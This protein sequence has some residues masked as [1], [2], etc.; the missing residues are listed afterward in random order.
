MKTIRTTLFSALLTTSLLSAEPL[1]TQEG[2]DPSFAEVLK[3][4]GVKPGERFSQGPVLGSR[5]H[6]N[7]ELLEKQVGKAGPIPKDIGLHTEGS[8]GIN[9]KDFGKWTRWYQEDGNTQVFRLFKG[10]Q[11]VRGGTGKDGSPGR[12]EAFSHNITVAPGTWHEWEG[13]Y[14]VIKPVGA[15]IFQL[16]HEGSLWP[17][18]IEMSEKGDISFLRRRPVP[19]MER[20][21]VIAENMVG[22]SL[23]I[24]VRANGDDYEVYQ[25]APLDKGEWKLVTKGSFTKAKDSKIS[26]RW[27]MYAGSKKG[28]AIKND[29]LL[30][31]TSVTIR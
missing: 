1:Y 29:A 5:I 16:M 12:V 28:E 27:G 31:V 25:K 3:S 13:T 10:E 11:N 21:I 19:G 24:K 15:C 20:E 18:H 26:F 7:N 30:F 8:G 14:T 17:F 6:V 23:S 2:S 9:R 4:S 22:K